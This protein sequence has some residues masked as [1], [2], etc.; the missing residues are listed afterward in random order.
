MKKLV[1]L[2][3]L[4]LLLSGCPNS[5]IPKP[6]PKVPEPKLIT[7]TMDGAAAMLSHGIGVGGTGLRHS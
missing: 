5:K 1:P 4:A 7:A 3:L 2:T 6:P